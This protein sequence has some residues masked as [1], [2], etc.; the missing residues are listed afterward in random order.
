MNERVLIVGAGAVG[1]VYGRHLQR[2]G[3]SV[4]FLVRPRYAARVRQGF[5]MANLN[6]GAA[7]ERFEGFEVLEDLDGVQVARWDQ[8]WLCVSSPALRGDWLGPTLSAVGQARVVSFQPGL[9]DS[10]LLSPHL[11]PERRLKG[12]I[13]FSAW[14]A[15]LPGAPTGPAH[16]AYWSPPLSPN[17]FQGPGAA[18]IAACLRAG[19]LSARQGPAEEMTARGSAILLPAVAAMECAGWTFSG[20]RSAPWASLA[21][22]SA[23]EALTIVSAHLG[24]S[25]GPM[26]VLTG[27]GLLRLLSHAAPLVAPFDI[28]RFFEAHFRKVGE[29][30]SLALKSW[31]S[32]GEARGL[33]VQSLQELDMEL[34]RSRHA[35]DADHS[36]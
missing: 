16:L 33:P 11:P 4:G 22:R 28:E 19:G 34:T 3:A 23:A 5:A 31:I 9:R 24:F 10:E 2:G 20:L 7:I 35:T 27:A 6:R 1:Q 30:T 15:P 14:D 17:L 25:P 26:G 29:Q 21:G 36:K 32:E 18:E 13:T 8:L 12:L